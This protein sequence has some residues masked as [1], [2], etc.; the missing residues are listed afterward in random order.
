MNEKIN[1]SK[2][3]V[4]FY[5]DKNSEDLLIDIFIN[6]LK[7]SNK[8]DKSSIICEAIELL[9][10]KDLDDL[11]EPLSEEVLNSKLNELRQLPEIQE[12]EQL[13]KFLKYLKSRE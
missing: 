9:H 8:S 3:K 4:T 12:Y 13:A 7:S 10:Q 11:Y 2:K 1:E 5:L 6:R